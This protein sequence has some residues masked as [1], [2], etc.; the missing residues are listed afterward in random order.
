MEYTVGTD[1]NGRPKAEHI[2]A[3]GGGWIAVP[4]RED[5]EGAVPRRARGR[6]SGEPSKNVEEAAV[7]EEKEEA[8][9]PP[10]GRKPRRRQPGRAAPTNRRTS[11]PTTS[12]KASFWHSALSEEVKDVLGTKNVPMKFSSMDIAVEGKARI[13]LGNDGYATCV[14]VNGTIAEGS[15]ES[16]AEGNVTLTWDRCIALDP[17]TKTWGAAEAKE[18]VLPSHVSLVADS[19]TSVQAGDEVAKLWKEDETVPDPKDVLEEHGFAMRRV[20]WAPP[21]QGRRGRGWGNK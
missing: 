8:P 16:D 5:G 14:N 7:Q 12:R 17:V 21:G 19:V 2:T 20:F 15:F 9:A 4:R 13:K 11:P 6:G 10:A 18:E 1:E 3:V